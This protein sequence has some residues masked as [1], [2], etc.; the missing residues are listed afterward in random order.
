MT[1]KPKM[2]YLQIEARNCVFGLDFVIRVHLIQEHAHSLSGRL[3]E[4]YYVSL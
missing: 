1:Y 4:C 3:M 2:H